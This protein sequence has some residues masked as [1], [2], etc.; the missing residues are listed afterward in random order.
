[1]TIKL[2]IDNRERKLLALIPDAEV[3]SLDI[4]DIQFI[5]DGE[6]IL[7]IERK[8]VKDLAASICD[9]R[10]R[11]Q[12]ARLL[13]SGIARERV[14][15][16]IEGDLSGNSKSKVGSLPLGTLLGAIINMQL[17]DGLQVHKTTS[18]A[19]TATFIKKLHDKLT[20]NR[21]DFWKFSDEG[22]MSASK[23]SSTLK[24]KKKQNMTPEVWLISQLAL[25][26]QFTEKMAASIHEVYPTMRD[27]VMAYEDTPDHLR[28]KLI[29][30][31]KYKL[32]TGK[33][34]RIGPR[35]SERVYKFVYALSDE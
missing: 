35:I 21:S 26:P 13:N 18:L 20:K 7:V 34:R 4:G 5:C 2:V 31:L 12:K 8:G 23:Y 28:P 14:M 15:Y 30:D 16:L 27:L 29:A 22:K 24:R 10:A 11:E 32:T 17:R 19:E 1:M 6:I 3:A 33:E 9:G 25:L